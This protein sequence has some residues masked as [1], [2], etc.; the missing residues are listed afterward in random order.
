MKSNYFFGSSPRHI[1]FFFFF[2]IFIDLANSYTSPVLK[3][4]AA[5]K[6]RVLT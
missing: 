3:L 6:V 1:F 4:F 2:L 5:K